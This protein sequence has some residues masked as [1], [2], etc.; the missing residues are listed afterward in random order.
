MKKP[1]YVT[2]IEASKILGKQRRTAHNILLCLVNNPDSPKDHPFHYKCYEKNV[3]QNYFRKDKV[4]ELLNKPK[5]RKHKTTCIECGIRFYTS[6]KNPVCPL[7]DVLSKDFMSER[8][9]LGYRTL[10]R[11]LTS[12]HWFRIVTK[13]ILISGIATLAIMIIGNEFIN[14][15]VNNEASLCLNQ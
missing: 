13:V 2:T 14:K 15:K 10:L 9:N 6:S 5:N 8:A 3:W 11:V 12:E 7:C 4:L 1:G